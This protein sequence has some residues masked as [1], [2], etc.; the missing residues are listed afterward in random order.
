MIIDIG[1]GSVL[2]AIG[3]SDP[4]LKA[5]Q[6]VWSHREQAPLKNIDSMEQSLK[7]VMTALVNAMMMLDSGGREALKVFSPHQKITELLC[8]IS[9]PWSYTV[10]K[11]INYKADEE[12]VV[13][14][15]MIKEFAETIEEQ[16]NQ[17]FSENSAL[18]KLNLEKICKLTMNLSA[19]GYHIQKPVGNKATQLSLAQ[20]NAVA[21]KAIVEAVD[22][23]QDKL[24]SGTDSKKLSFMLLLY[25]VSREILNQAYDICLIDITYEATEIGIVRDGVLSYSTHTAFGSF[26]IARE[27]ANICQIPLTEAYGHLHNEDPYGF[28]DNFT[29]RQQKEIE[30]VFEAYTERITRLLNETGDSLSIPKQISIHSDLRSEGLFSDLV[31]KAAKRNLKSEPS[32]SC[33]SKEL[34]KLCYKEQTKDTKVYIPV[35]TALILSAQFFHNKGV[36][37]DLK[38]Y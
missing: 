17:D 25:S 28:L 16:I 14:E 20:G 26:S 37:F 15:E 3:I 10:T 5:P 1:S 21:Q 36:R 8:C 35:D 24:L 2:V 13:S 22:E 30:L 33:I 27:I 32:V 12:F 18:Q 31:S 34:I 7:A 29:D 19:N 6:V 11:T 38:H 4:K 9:A 23:L